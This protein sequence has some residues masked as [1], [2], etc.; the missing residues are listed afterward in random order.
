MLGNPATISEALLQAA[1]LPFMDEDKVRFKQK[2]LQYI[3]G[4]SD[5]QLIQ[6][7]SQMKGFLSMY[8]GYSVRETDGEG[9]RGYTFDDYN[10]WHYLDKENFRGRVREICC[11]RDN[12]VKV[13]F[14]EHN[15]DA[16]SDQMAEILRSFIKEDHKEIH[17]SLNPPEGQMSHVI[18]FDNSEKLGGYWTDFMRKIFSV[19]PIHE[20]IHEELRLKTDFYAKS[21]IIVHSIGKLDITFW[22][23]FQLY[24]SFWVSLRPEHPVF[25]CMFLPPEHSLPRDINPLPHWI[26]CYCNE[27]ETV[28]PYHFTCFFSDYKCYQKDEKLCRCTPMCFSDAVKELRYC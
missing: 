23:K 16:F 27:Y 22:D 20:K 21:H 17:E 5:H 9:F 7:I 10:Q 14:I 8:D 19:P 2:R 4:M 28:G 25:L 11:D 24:Y 6:W 15:V 1:K 12:L 26:L 18:K 3:D 13:I